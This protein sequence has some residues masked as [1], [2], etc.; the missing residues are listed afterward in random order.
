MKFA[1]SLKQIKFCIVGAG[2]SGIMCGHFFRLMGVQFDI[3]EKG[4]AP[5]GTWYWNR[6][7]GIGCDIE[8]HLYSLSFFRKS[9]WS[10]VFSLGD[11]IQEYMIAAWKFAKESRQFLLKCSPLIDSRN[12]SYFENWPK[13]EK[14]SKFNCEV[15]KAVWKKDEEVWEVTFTDM[16]FRIK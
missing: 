13:L 8:S 3:I 15:T 5:G 14:Y 16:S 1:P 6:Y 9:D 4:S 11:E 10:K 12:I 7:P 2:V